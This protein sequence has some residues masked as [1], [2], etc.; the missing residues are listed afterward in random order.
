MPQV[1]V[2]RLNSRI[3]IQTFSRINNRLI[4]TGE[5]NSIFFVV[6]EASQQWYFSWILGMHCKKVKLNDPC[7]SLRKKLRWM[8]WTFNLELYQSRV[9]GN[10][11]LQKQ[12]WEPFHGGW[13]RIFHDNPST[14]YSDGGELPHE[15]NGWIHFS[16][17]TYACEQNQWA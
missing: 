1:V 11:L 15:A 7:I 8:V 6:N 2:P 16:F 5:L 9:C 10:I 13:R 17:H 12:I 14:D 4:P 3:A